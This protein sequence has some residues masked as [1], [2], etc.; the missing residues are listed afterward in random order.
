MSSCAG[1]QGASGADAFD[2]VIVVAGLLSMGVTDRWYSYGLM[3]QRSLEVFTEWLN[4]ERGGVRVG[5]KRYGVRFV[6]FDDAASTSQTA[7]ALASALRLTGADFAWAGYSSGLTLYAAQQSA[8]DD[9]ILMSGGA[10]STS[11]FSQPGEQF[12]LLPPSTRYT[13]VALVSI[14]EAAKALDAN[15][16]SSTSSLVPQWAARGYPCGAVGGGGGKPSCV[17]MLKAGFIQADALFSKGVCTASIAQARGLGMAVHDASGDGTSVAATVP[18]APTAAEVGAVMAS[19]RDAGVTVVVGCTYVQTGIP[20][21]E[22]LEALDYSPLAVVTTSTVSH[23]SFFAKVNAGWWQGEYVLEATPWHHLNPVRGALS[24]MTSIEFFERFKARFGGDEVAYQGAAQFGAGCALVRAIES[25]GSLGTKEVAAELR[26]LKLAEFY[27]D[28]GFDANGQTTQGL[29]LLQYGRGK[30]QLG[31]V[32]PPGASTQPIAFPAPTWA[33]RRCHRGQLTGACSLDHGYCSS[34]GACLCD[35][36]WTGTDCACRGV[37]IPTVLSVSPE[38]LSPFGGDILTITGENFDG[39]GGEMKGLD[40]GSGDVFVSVTIG[41]TLCG[42]ATLVSPTTITC[43]SPGGVGG[44]RSISVN[45][46]GKESAPRFLISYYLPE[47]QG[48][49]TGWGVEGTVLDITGANYVKFSMRCRVGSTGPV[50][51]AVWKD[52]HHIQCTMPMGTLVGIQS[53][54]LSNDG[55]VRWASGLSVQSD[56]HWYKGLAQPTDGLMLPPT[57]LTLG[58]LA[59]VDYFVKT[60]GADVR[61]PAEAAIQALNAQGLLPPGF[62]IKLSIVDN[63]A[64]MAGGIAGARQLIAESENLVGIVGGYFS[65][66]TMGAA[67]VTMRSRVPYVGLQA[68]SSLLENKDAETGFPYFVR[69]GSDNRASA[70]ALVRFAGFMGWKKVAIISSNDA[71]AADFNRLVDAALEGGAMYRGEIADSGADE[72]PMYAAT[73]VHAKKIAALGIKI[74]VIE[75]SF[76]RT[77]AAIVRA[78]HDT[79]LSGEGYAYIGEYGMRLAMVSLQKTQTAGPAVPGTW[80]AAF[81]GVFLV[82]VTMGSTCRGPY[83]T[84][85]ELGNS[86]DGVYLLVRAIAAAA[87][88]RGS[89]FWGQYIAGD[90]DARGAVMAA[91]RATDLTI[92]L[93]GSHIKFE[94]MTN[95]RDQSTL[96]YLVTNYNAASQA[97]PWPHDTVVGRIVGAGV[98]MDHSATLRWAGGAVQA[99]NDGSTLR[100]VRLHVMSYRD[101]NEALWLAEQAAHEMNSDPNILATTRL[102]VNHTL[103]D[104]GT[105]AS[106]IAAASQAIEDAKSRSQPIYALITSGHSLSRPLLKAPALQGVPVVSYSTTLPEFQNQSMYPNFVRVVNSARLT[107]DA[108]GVL[109]AGLGWSRF[110]LIFDE[111]NKGMR[112]AAAGLAKQSGI[113]AVLAPCN[114]E[115]SDDEI[116]S[117]ARGVAKRAVAERH[118][119]FLFLVADKTM[120]SVLLDEAVAHDL[121]KGGHQLV[122]GDLSG[123][124]KKAFTKAAV[125]STQSDPD[126]VRAAFDGFL[127]ID[128][129]PMADTTRAKRAS[130]FWSKTVRSG[131]LPFKWDGMTLEKATS[132][133]E[134]ETIFAN[135]YQKVMSFFYDAVVF[136]GHAL[137][138]CMVASACS[139]SS[140]DDLGKQLRTSVV[141]GVTGRLSV[142]EGSND[143]N[144]MVY[145]DEHLYNIQC[146][147]ICTLRNEKFHTEI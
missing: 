21:V 12:G 36:G 67:N 34:V 135:S 113:E 56:I 61:V 89:E 122:F 1:S 38:W 129:V 5:G 19:F 128:V 123:T 79:G 42:N 69:I 53:L 47:L 7:P 29:I 14:V 120:L 105:D 55:G 50:T 88:T 141:N 140:G 87:L 71:Y 2:G 22:S 27:G 59:P 54:Y 23:P 131:V 138:D 48:I 130:A 41:G 85:Y 133:G 144:T 51:L 70:E 49:S 101:Y 25:A 121:F 20:L 75:T 82:G 46:N 103:V 11:V 80:Q 139:P 13:T 6:W 86:Y 78:L 57:Q 43:K 114:S 65:L 68:A 77:A 17:G 116:R 30:M 106:Y 4:E 24:N 84:V 93:Q 26:A 83:C 96:R 119:I 142:E 28:I 115:V 40:G 72:E 16:T 31:I 18:K 104:R 63:N 145:V 81:D 33:Q 58:M 125:L 126:K 74:I 111:E 94:P 64:T 90:A 39:K 136:A 76:G 52:A 146:S 147:E 124:A 44:A 8:A 37:C 60:L 66:V 62:T 107:S 112:A 98:E 134:L 143:R 102:I 91:L 109:V 117:C 108:I 137:H 92:P 127:E 97:G 95:N 35:A 110:L 73:L 132:L 10:S 32:G 15:A 99:P 3:I 45:A 9:R 100:E 118:S